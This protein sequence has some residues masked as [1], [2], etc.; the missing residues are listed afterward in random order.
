MVYNYTP[1]TS[2]LTHHKKFKGVP[3]KTVP[4]KRSKA[5]VEVYFS[6]IFPT[7]KECDEFVEN[8]KKGNVFR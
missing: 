2:H 8:V 4:K 7:D 6:L 5:K 1:R 3:Y